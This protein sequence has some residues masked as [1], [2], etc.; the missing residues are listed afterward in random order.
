MRGHGFPWFRLLMALLVF[1]AGFI[2][3]DIR[4]HGSFAGLSDLHTGITLVN[5]T[6]KAMLN[7]ILPQAESAGFWTKLVL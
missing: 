2:A 1:A 6:L 3:H 7:L 4:L 5:R